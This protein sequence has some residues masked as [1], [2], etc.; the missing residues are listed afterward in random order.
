MNLFCLLVLGFSKNFESELAEL[1]KATSNQ[2]SIIPDDSGQEFRKKA[3]ELVNARL[4][5][6]KLVISRPKTLN[7]RISSNSSLPSGALGTSR[8]SRKEPSQ[9][10]SL[11]NVTSFTIGDSQGG[12]GIIYNNIV[13]L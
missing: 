3:D 13:S 2:D 5:I 12:E 1:S 4:D 8:E 6:T 10:S 9:K 7:S 11:R